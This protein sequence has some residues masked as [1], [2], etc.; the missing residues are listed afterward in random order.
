MDLIIFDFDGT[1]AD[2]WRDIA[3]AL[4]QT[5]REAGLAEASAE[6]VRAWIGDGVVR[7]LERAVPA[8]RRA[9]D[10]MATLHARFRDHYQRCCLDTTTLYPG[11]ADCLAEL[12][13][14]AL[15][16]LSNKPAQFLDRMVAG[17]GVAPCFAAVVGGD[18]LAVRKPDPA[19]VEHVA[20][21]VGVRADRLWMVGDSA[22]DVATG[23]VAGARCIGCT[24]GL[25]GAAEL[26]AAGVDFL[27]AHPR[28]IPPL[29]KAR[30]SQTLV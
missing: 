16:I 24:W 7:L 5:L 10:G 27:V 11:I 2:T 18:A 1:L 15:A 28:E 25:R 26:R 3:T 22:I 20:R 30:S 8:Q 23:R 6:Q 9:G 12:R 13:G 29:I 19:L 17:L 14:H 21:R 4:N